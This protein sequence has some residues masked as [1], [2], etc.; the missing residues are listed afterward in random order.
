MGWVFRDLENF[1]SFRKI[2]IRLRGKINF[3]FFLLRKK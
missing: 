1:E 2:L 3:G